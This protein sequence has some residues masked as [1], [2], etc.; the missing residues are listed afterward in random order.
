M[1]SHEHEF[2]C[3]EYNLFKKIQSEMSILFYF[4]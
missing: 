1:L 4:V 3:N 2:F